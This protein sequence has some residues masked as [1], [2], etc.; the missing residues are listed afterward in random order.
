MK[1][2]SRQQGAEVRGTGPRFPPGSGEGPSRLFQPLGLQR[3]GLVAMSPHLCLCLHVTSA[4]CRVGCPPVSFL[5]VTASR[6]HQ[7]DLPIRKSE[8]KCICRDS[9]SK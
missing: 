1:V 2:Q 9:S 5:Y 8:S 6:V 7:D 4:V 3:P